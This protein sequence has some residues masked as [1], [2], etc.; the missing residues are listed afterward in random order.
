MN[1]DGIF[2]GQG[3]CGLPCGIQR[4][5][6]VESIDHNRIENIKELGRGAYGCVFQAYLSN[7]GNLAELLIPFLTKSFKGPSRKRGI[8]KRPSSTGPQ[9][10]SAVREIPKSTK[11]TV[12]V[13]YISKNQYVCDYLREICGLSVLN[14]QNIVHLHGYGGTE[15][16][17]FIVMEL[18]EVSLKEAIR[19]NQI[20]SDRKLS[21][22]RQTAEG[23]QYLHGRGMLHR[24]LKP[25]NLL[26]F[27]NGETIKL[28]DF[29]LVTERTIS[30]A[31]GDRRYWDPQVWQTGHCSI[32]SDIYS[33]A[34]TM[35]EMYAG[36]DPDWNSQGKRPDIPSDW[37]AI[38][39]ALI[40]RCLRHEA[41]AI[42]S[43][44]TVIGGIHEN[45]VVEIA[46]QGL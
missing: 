7:E 19:K 36:Q 20:N 32:K 29:G 24:D 46:D 2:P 33:W 9:K 44:D 6:P 39:R 28:G 37:P 5:N 21:Y 30:D 25:D 3:P 1:L 27:N 15:T 35:W 42:M 31:H 23:L 10:L 40:P 26:I 41:C 38:V 43:M 34:V 45:E 18:A 16:H 8:A 22:L 12:A 14:H 13:K 17:Y 4:C 11:H